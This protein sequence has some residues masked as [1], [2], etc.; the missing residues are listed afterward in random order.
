[1]ATIP[2]VIVISPVRIYRESLAAALCGQGSLEVLGT[3]A[4]PDEARGHA[5][6][7]VPDVLLVDVGTAHSVRMITDLARTYPDAALVALASPEEDEDIVACAAAGVAG[8]VASEGSL[9]DVVGTV[10]SVARGDAV[11]SPRVTAALLRRVSGTG[12]EPARAAAQIRL[13]PRERQIVGLIDTGLSN[14]EIASRLYIEVSTVKNHV[15]NILTK[16]GAQRRSQA[17]ARART[18][19]SSG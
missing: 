2:A 17:A 5:T 1:M 10:E 18:V 13:T 6:D 8:F 9:D 19:S 11:C 15:H 14:K 7:R 4:T 3:A 16:L 12:G